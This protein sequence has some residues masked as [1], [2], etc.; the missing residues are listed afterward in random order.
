MYALFAAVYDWML[1]IEEKKTIE[2]RFGLFLMKP[3][4]FFI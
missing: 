2:Q 4:I 1:P 3:H